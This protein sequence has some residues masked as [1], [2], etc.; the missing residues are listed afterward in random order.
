MKICLTLFILLH[1]VSQ[2]SY[3]QIFVSGQASAS[4]LQ[5]G[6][7][8]SRY[9]VNEGR[10]TFAW[11]LDVFADAIISE[12]LKFYSNIRITEEQRLNIDLLKLRVTDIAGLGLNANIGKIF[13]PFG[14]LG[15]RRYPK[16]NPFFHLPL[17]NEH[18]TTLA[19]SDYSL[20][21]L[22]PMQVISGNGFRLLD[23]G[24]YDAGISLDGS[25]GKIEYALA[26][27]NGA[28]S[29]TSSYTASGLNN[30][31]GFGSVA[32]IAYVPSE[33]FSLGGSFGYGPFISENNPQGEDP[34]HYPQRITGIDISYSLGYFS[35][36]GEAIYNNWMFD[37]EPDLNAFAYSAEIHYTIIPRILCAVRVGGIR[38]NEITADVYSQDGTYGTYTGTWDDIVVRYETA[39]QYRIEKDA[40]IKLVY[41]IYSTY[42]NFGDPSDN[43]LVLQTVFGF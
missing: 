9:T 41:E 19:L 25:V 1:L 40:L 34:N 32:H 39:L 8:L 11:R 30:N 24:L 37:D 6:E 35:F 12:N 20:H 10:G 23:Y 27:I 26:L 18:I 14:S 29:A 21:T 13:I 17:M 4:Y 2:F 31:Q 16:Q 22:D 15:E 28:V 43:L 42:G 3:A 38:F 5:S 7:A 33:E 36:F